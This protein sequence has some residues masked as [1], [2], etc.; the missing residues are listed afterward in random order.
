MAI[1]VTS[2]NSAVLQSQVAQ[3]LV[4]PLEQASTFLA[5]GP[6]ILD[7]ASPVRIPRIA[8][9]VTAGFVA[10]G[11]QITDGSVSLDEI[12][13]MPSTLKSLKVLVRVSNELVRQSVI[14]L[15]AVLQ[16]RLVADVANAL[17]AA[18]WSGSGSSNTVKGVINQ[19]GVATGALDITDADSLI[20]GIATAMANKVIPSHWAMTAATFNAFRKIKV[21]TTDARYVFDP[22]TIQSGTAFQLF[23]LPVLITDN[24]PDAAA[25]RPQV[26]LVDFS[27]VV[28]VRDVD[29]SV[30]IL[31]QT[32]GDYDSVGIRVVTRYDVALLQP[33]AVTLLTTPA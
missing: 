20:D 8:S 4:Q 19:T 33:H 28:V 24:I 10:E 18:L 5:A 22:S 16:Q 26:A 15:D 9:G 17:D 3:L 25:G 32:W 30:F 1:E 2:G 6:V 27:K 7:S 14:G 31:D 11:A 21:G 29:A 13:L 23:G 12:D